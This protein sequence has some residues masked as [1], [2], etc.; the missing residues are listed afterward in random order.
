MWKRAVWI[1]ALLAAVAGCGQSGDGQSG[2]S[3]KIEP[4]VFTQKMENGLE[5]TIEIQYEDMEGAK[6]RV[7][8]GKAGSFQLGE[9]LQV[10]AKV[11]NAS[12]KDFVF[13]GDPCSGHLSVRLV[14]DTVR[15]S[16][17][18]DIAGDVCIQSIETHTLKAGETITAKAVFPLDKGVD[19]G[20]VAGEE[21]D[22]EPGTYTVR[23]HYAMQVMEAEIELHNREE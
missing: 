2:G 16:G 9:P 4:S 5:Y 23:A 22:L 21:V 11:N 10:T 15:V 8:K 20:T 6:G 14:K 17:E 3:E 18:G 7:T 13:E 19:S 1:I 12:G